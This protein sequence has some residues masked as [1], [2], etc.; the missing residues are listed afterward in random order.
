VI[1]SIYRILY[2]AASVYWSLVRPVT[3]GVRVILERDGKV[4]LVKHTY[5]DGWFLP[6]G[7][8]K[9]GETLE[10]AA[11]R[12]VS[13]EVGVQTKTMCL[14]GVYF[15]TSEYKSD[16][17][18]VFS[19]ADFVLSGKMDYEIACCAWFSFDKLP[20]STGDGTKRRLMEY[21][22]GKHAARTGLW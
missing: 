1:R 9:R 14:H 6:G 12:E 11:R 21:A 7:G 22:S 16:H 17:I 3:L 2:L 4:L 19:C 18:G 15:N 20:V 8:V 5:R 10:Q 13:E